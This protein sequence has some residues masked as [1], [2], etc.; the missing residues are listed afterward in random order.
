MAFRHYL[1]LTAALLVISASAELEPRLFGVGQDNAPA[2]NNENRGWCYFCSDD[3]A[4]PLCNTQCAT[5][6]N[7]LCSVEE[8]SIPLT[9]T[10]KDCTIQYF[11]P[12]YGSRSTD[13]PIAVDR[14]TCISGFTGIMNMCGKDA[15]DA[16][17]TFDPAYCTTSGGG[18]TYG[19]NDD[20][21][22]M[23]GTARYVVVTK[24]TDQCGQHEAS[25]KQ[26]TSVIQW[27]DSWVGPYDQVVLDTNPPAASISDFPEPP[28]PNPE[29]ETEVCDIYDHP[30]YAKQGKPNWNENEGWTRFQVLY[31]GFAEDPGAAALVKALV[32]RCKIEPKNFQ[33][34]FEDNTNKAD[35]E[36][37]SNN[38]VEKCD[39]IP[40]AIYD[41]SVGL[42]LD[43]LTWCV[44]QNSQAKHPEFV[45]VQ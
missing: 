24:G 7:R 14:N 39:C 32:D 15:G 28:A 23:T 42:T 6:I 25:W 19:W 16:R 8:L 44:G 35:F 20:G 36:L 41:A 12:V 33:K 37:P 45:E 17:T 9:D 29:C 10:E 22:I 2:F 1:P 5:A 40:E 27:N 13:T 11:P 4:P 3:G 43:R 31:K 21:S 26:A 34:Y 38:R 18:G 30:Y